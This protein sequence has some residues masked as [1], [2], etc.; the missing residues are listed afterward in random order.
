ML[1]IFIIVL[2]T[3]LTFVSLSTCLLVGVVVVVYLIFKGLLFVC[4][5]FIQQTV[6]LHILL[7]LLDL[8]SFDIS[9]FV[10]EI[11]QMHIMYALLC[12]TSSPVLKWM[13]LI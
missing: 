7:C 13:A 6:I 1:Y 3:N 12:K 4:L 11:F 8:L 2:K 10:P 5:F 9:T